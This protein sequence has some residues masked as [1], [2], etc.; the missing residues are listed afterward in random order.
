MI[1]NDVARGEHMRHGRG[2][3]KRLPDGIWRKG[4]LAA[5]LTL[6]GL[7]AAG[8]ATQGTVGTAARGDL[9]LSYAMPEAPG[10][11]IPYRVFLPSGWNAQKTWPLVV[12]LHG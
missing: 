3:A 10:E 1:R 7:Q 8:C 9:H 4:S 5:L 6:A 2:R 11:T 12:V